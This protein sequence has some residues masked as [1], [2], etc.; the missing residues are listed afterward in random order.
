M[1]RVQLEQEAAPGQVSGRERRKLAGFEP[2]KTA[3]G[4]HI[5][6]AGRTGHGGET[7]EKLEIL[8]LP[9][10]RE[11]DKSSWRARGGEKSVT[12]CPTVSVPSPSAPPRRR[13][14]P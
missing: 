14:T 6:R 7:H 8:Q 4:Y 1:R 5:D 11:S 10:L 12:M 13:T 3:A 9:H 2:G